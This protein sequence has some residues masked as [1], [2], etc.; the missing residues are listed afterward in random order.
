M[1]TNRFQVKFDNQ[2]SGPFLELTELKIKSEALLSAW[3]HNLSEAV[4]T[5]DVLEICHYF[6]I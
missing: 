4:D 1:A 2:L 3:Y 5:L 6:D